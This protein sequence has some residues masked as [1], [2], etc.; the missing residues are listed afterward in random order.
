MKVIKKMGTIIM[1]L[2]AKNDYILLEQYNPKASDFTLPAGEVSEMKYKVMSVGSEVDDVNI[3]DIIICYV[4]PPFTV[5]DKTY[6]FTKETAII[7]GATNE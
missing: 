2:Y 4:E 3:D 7:A 1:K 5:D 6:W